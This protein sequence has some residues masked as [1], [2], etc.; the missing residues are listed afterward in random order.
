MNE[1][2][3]CHVTSSVPTLVS[4]Q[5][6]YTDMLTSISVYCVA[7]DE[8]TS[9]ENHSTHRPDEDIT[10]PLQMVAHTMSC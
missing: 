2:Y 3:A 6:L 9:L 5:T 4:T 8:S 7:V 1:S 10:H